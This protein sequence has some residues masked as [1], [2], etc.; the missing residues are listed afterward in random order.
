MLVFTGSLLPYEYTQVVTCNLTLLTRC[1][2]VD[3]VH[4]DSVHVDSVHVDIHCKCQGFNYILRNIITYCVQAVY[5][6]QASNGMRLCLAL[7]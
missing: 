1:S 7:A 6:V 4:V 2:G 3:S 5:S